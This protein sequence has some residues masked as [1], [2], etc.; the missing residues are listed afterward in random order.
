MCC[1]GS[2]LA[3]EDLLSMCDVQQAPLEFWWR[4]PLDMRCS[5]LTGWGVGG[6]MGRVLSTFG[7]RGS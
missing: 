2:L 6:S 1:E 7:A 5:V 3:A 4:A